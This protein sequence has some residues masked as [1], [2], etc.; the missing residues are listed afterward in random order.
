V[1]LP[2]SA[3][4]VAVRSAGVTVFRS[5]GVLPGADLGALRNVLV[6]PTVTGWRLYKDGTGSN[7]A[8]P[9]LLH[10]EGTWV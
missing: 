8:F 2:Y 3:A 6:V 5:D 7:T 9:L 10:A 1:D 4:F